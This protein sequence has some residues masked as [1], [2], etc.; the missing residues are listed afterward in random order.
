MSSARVLYTSAASSVQGT[1]S[2]HHY[3]LG[4]KIQQQNP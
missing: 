4:I 3:L 2:A 1:L